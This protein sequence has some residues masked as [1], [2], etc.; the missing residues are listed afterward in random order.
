LDTSYLWRKDE[1][2][3]IAVDHDHNAD[4]PGR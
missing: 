3:V 4:A 2:L 1:T